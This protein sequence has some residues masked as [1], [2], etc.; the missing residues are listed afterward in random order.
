MRFTTALSVPLAAAAL[1]TACAPPALRADPAPQA[2]A[3]KEAGTPAA[4]LERE[5]QVR[6]YR[7]ETGAIWDDRGQKQAAK[8]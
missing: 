6:Y 4:S 8:P 3:S 5:R 1:A 7:D 2:A